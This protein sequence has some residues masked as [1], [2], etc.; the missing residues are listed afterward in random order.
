MTELFN[1]FYHCQ[2]SNSYE[3]YLD[4]AGEVVLLKYSIT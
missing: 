3:W 1:G 4:S 2:G